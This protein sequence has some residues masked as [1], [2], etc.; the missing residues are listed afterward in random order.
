[1]LPERFRRQADAM[2]RTGRSPL[3]VALIR[4]AADD[5]E[6]RGPVARLFE[7]IDAPAGSVPSLRLMAAP[8]YLA[9]SG[10]APLSLD[11][12]DEHFDEVHARLRRGVQTNDVGRAA[13]LYDRPGRS[14]R[15]PAHC[16]AAGC[17]LAPLDPTSDED[18]LTLLSYIGQSVFRQYLSDGEWH[19]LEAAQPDGSVWLRMEPTD[20]PA[21]DAELTICEAP[22]EPPRRLALCSFHG[23]PVV[24]SEG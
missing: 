15:A 2:E 21:A 24:W 7:G 9:L 3:Y 1:M 12:I 10:R 19:E 6:A 14:R 23:A 18:R 16:G 13:V 20:D 8:H 5:I 17:D 22:G 11:A 4:E